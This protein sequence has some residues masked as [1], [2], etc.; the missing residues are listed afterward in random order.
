[1]AH[2][3]Q[4]TP[5]SQSAPAAQRVPVPGQVEPRH[6]SGIGAPQSMVLAG[7]HTSVHVQAPLEHVSAPG[8][9]P[10]HAPPQPSSSPHAA[11][12]PQRGAHTHVPLDVSH[13]SRAPA[14]VPSQ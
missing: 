5:S 7:R 10:G 12:A 3:G 8:H 13:S 11:P 1:M 14:Q 4:Q 9:A 2:G 6:E